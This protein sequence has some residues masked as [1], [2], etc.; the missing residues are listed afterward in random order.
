MELIWNEINAL[1][2]VLRRTEQVR[3]EG[4]VPPPAGRTAAEL[5]DYGAEAAVQSCRIDAGG[6]TVEGSIIAKLAAMDEAGELFAFTSESAFS[7]RLEDPAIEAGSIASVLPSLTLLS[8]RRAPDGRLLLSAAIDLDCLV[9]AAGSIKTLGGVSG[10]P[11][12]ELRTGEAVL[13]RRRE[14]GSASVQLREE[15]SSGGAEA[16]LTSSCSLTVRE[17]AFENGGVTV[18]GTAAVSALLRCE[19]GSLTQFVR[20]IPFR[21]SVLTDGAADEV[22]ASAELKSFALRALGTEFSVVTVDAEIAL[23]V[24]TAAPERLILP[25]DAFSPAINFSCIR[26]ETALLSCLGGTDASHTLRESVTVP[27]GMA[28]ILSP[29]SA[30]A[31][32]I[33]TGCSFEN[34]RMQVEGLLPTRLIYRSASGRLEAFS[35]DVPFALELAP[36]GADRAAFARLRSGCTCSVSG[37]GGR[38]AQLTYLVDF[39]AELYSV[40]NASVVAGLAEQNAE[41]AREAALPEG[42]SGLVLH[43]AAEGESV[44]DV[45]KRFRVPSAGIRALNPELPETLSDG[46]K[47][48]IMI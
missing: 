27:E 6:L 21:E 7:H 18:S 13:S 16:V 31:R 23:S 41:T 36:K 44:F 42:F 26:R 11:D 17:T 4:E 28:D 29:V 37:G 25:L 34:G 15:F 22:F 9:T 40:H 19:D 8:V 5:I 38:A 3:I 35:E 33:V 46:E 2:L 43:A 30:S 32:A 24:F 48:L 45:A 14:I 20:S 39:S 12:L 1:S 10:V 47:V